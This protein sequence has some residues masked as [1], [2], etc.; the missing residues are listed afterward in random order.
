MTKKLK[1][2]ITYL[3]QRTRPALP[4]APSPPG[5]IA[6]LR[7]E[8]PPLHFYRYL[9]DVVG[10]PYNWVSR[11]RM[12]DETLT[13]IIH[14][15]ATHL[16]ILYVEGVPAGLAEIDA[17]S[18]QNVE[19]KFFGLTP[20]YTGRRLGRYFLTQAINL[21]WSL[22]PE[23]VMLETCTLDHPA[24]LPLYQK[25]GFSVFDQKQGEVE[26]MDSPASA[27]TV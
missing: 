24:A 6:I 4:P 8:K 9:Y 19:I 1:V 27:E 20:D 18:P 2:Q 26:L 3:E 23:R 14:D 5:K 15:P 12:D 22:G 11:K 7:A 17:T 10:G 25:L 13:S 16:Y 21:A